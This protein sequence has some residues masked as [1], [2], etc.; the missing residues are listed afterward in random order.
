M[1]FDGGEMFHRLPGLESPLSLSS[2]LFLTEC[3][4]MGF[5]DL[6][7]PA[8]QEVPRIDTAVD[9]FICSGTK[10]SDEETEAREGQR[11]KSIYSIKRNLLFSFSFL[12]LQTEAI[13]S[14]SLRVS[15]KQLH[16]QF[17]WKLSHIF[18]GE[19]DRLDRS[20]VMC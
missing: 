1:T 18:I 8:R 16:G 2:V 12:F 4:G 11:D 3:M 5:R 19:V 15:L 13:V 6:L 9:L 17:I 20:C 14:F 10:W 7:L